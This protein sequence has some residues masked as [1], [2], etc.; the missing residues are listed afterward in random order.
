MACRECLEFHATR[1]FVVTPQLQLKLDH[2][3]ARDQLKVPDVGRPHS[4]AEFQST[5]PISKSD[6]GMRTPLAWA[7]AVDLSGAEGDRNGHRLDGY[8][9][10]QLVK[11]SLPFSRG[12][13]LCWRG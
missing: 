12:V 6:S 11:E 3:Q 10:E 4:I 1:A 8:T 2:V 13:R 7:L 9:R 5:C